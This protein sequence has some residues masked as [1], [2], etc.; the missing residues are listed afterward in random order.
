MQSHS[1]RCFKDV[2]KSE[3]TEAYEIETYAIYRDIR[4]QILSSK[5]NQIRIVRLCCG[6][7][8]NEIE[9]WLQSWGFS[10]FQADKF[11]TAYDSYISLNDPELEIIEERKPLD[12]NKL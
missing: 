6:G 11:S 8:D 1:F 5:E 7:I 12:I 4:F 3:I 2:P 10:V 9:E